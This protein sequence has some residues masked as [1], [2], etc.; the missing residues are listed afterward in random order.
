MAVFLLRSLLG[1]EVFSAAGHGRRVFGRE[2]LDSFAAAWIE[3]LAA[4]GI[5]AGC[6]DGD[7]L[8]G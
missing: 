8:S 7:L 6:G 4:R 3:D 1:A 2:R 5:T